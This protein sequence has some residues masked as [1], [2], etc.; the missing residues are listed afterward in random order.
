[1]PEK[2][3]EKTKKPSPSKLLKVLV[4]AGM[5]LAGMSGARAAE[6]KPAPPTDEKTSAP[7]D[8]GDKAKTKEQQEKEKQAK[9]EKE[10]QEKKKADDEKKASQEGGGVKGW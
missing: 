1:M 3:T 5:A 4:A 7:A 8:A 9:A 2:K 10:K 6:D